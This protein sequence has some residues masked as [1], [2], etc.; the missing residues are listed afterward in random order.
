MN[1][2]LNE[3]AANI[4]KIENDFEKRLNHEGLYT[5]NDFILYNFKQNDEYVYIF[6]P[7]D[8]IKDDT[9]YLYIK[10]KFIK[11]LLYSQQLQDALNEKHLNI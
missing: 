11:I 10:D 1:N 8:A 6:V 7:I 3:L 4:L 9:C 5:K 2:T